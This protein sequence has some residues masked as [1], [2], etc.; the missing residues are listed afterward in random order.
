MKINICAK[1]SDMFSAHLIDDDGKVK[2]EAYDGYVPGW[3]PCDNGGD[4]VTLSIDVAT[5]KILNW[6]RPTRKE[7][8]ETFKFQRGVKKVDCQESRRKL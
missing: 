4:Y 2:G 5:G 3:M 6:K 8:A 1:C 7:L